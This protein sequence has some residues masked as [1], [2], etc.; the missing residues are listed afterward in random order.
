M[1]SKMF[2]FPFSVKYNTVSEYNLSSCEISCIKKKWKRSPF[3]LITKE[4]RSGEGKLETERDQGGI[5]QVQETD[6]MW[7]STTEEGFQ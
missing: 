2:R 3:S 5:N 1:Y 6:L 4:K 7:I